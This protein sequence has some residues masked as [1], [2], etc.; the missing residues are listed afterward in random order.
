MLLDDPVLYDPKNPTRMEKSA[1][2]SCMTIVYDA[3]LHG[4][5]IHGGCR[6][7]SGIVYNP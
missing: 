7:F 6:K 5:T 3:E 1:C 4:E 2:N